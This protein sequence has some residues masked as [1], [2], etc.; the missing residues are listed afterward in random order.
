MSLSNSITESAL[1][2]IDSTRV[3]KHRDIFAH[4][5]QY[6]FMKQLL[7][8]VNSLQ[9]KEFDFND[10]SHLAVNVVEKIGIF[11]NWERLSNKYV[12]ITIFWR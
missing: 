2:G 3:W 12:C 5:V 11:V 8:Q 1:F 4:L 10:D 9:F 6:D 7:F